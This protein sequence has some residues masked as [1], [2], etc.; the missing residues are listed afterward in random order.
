MKTSL[1]IVVARNKVFA[2]EPLVASGEAV[3]QSPSPRSARS[4]HPSYVK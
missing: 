3:F 1:R 4:V 2:T